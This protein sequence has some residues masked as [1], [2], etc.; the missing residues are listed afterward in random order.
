MSEMNANSRIF[1]AG[2]QTLAGKSL[3]AHLKQNGFS[4]VQ[5][6][7]AVRDGLQNAEGLPD[8]FKS[9]RPEYIFFTGASSLGIGANQKFPA[10]LFKENAAAALNLF[11][12]ARHCSP[13][14]ILYLASSCIYPVN[15]PQP[16]KP[17]TLGSGPLEATCKS[18]AQAK[19]FAIDLARA[20]EK[21]FGLKTITGIPADTFGPE[22][23]FHPEHSHVVTALIK[24]IHE[25]KVSGCPSITLWGSG[26]PVRDFLYSANLADACVFLMKNFE[27]A[28][29]INISAENYMSIT[30]LANRISQIVE[31]K[32][33]F[34]YDAG[35]PDG[36]PEKTLDA[37]EIK[38]LGWQPASSFEEGLRR[39]YQSFLMREQAHSHV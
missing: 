16:M 14:K 6:D 4:A 8:L 37:S 25:A 32:G 15:A 22:D 38:K 20:Y 24:K 18:F 29:P 30:Q 26:R 39:T 13:K 21:Q 10:E 7:A 9:F 12:A 1:V 34:N 19:I 31:F 33:Q 2:T 35:K 27:G 28:S 5:S 23:D 36:A 17:E 3:L 11:E